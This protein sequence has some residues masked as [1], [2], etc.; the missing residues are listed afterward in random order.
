MYNISIEVAGYCL[1]CLCFV[2]P[3]VSRFEIG[4]PFPVT[5]GLKVTAYNSHYIDRVRIW[6]RDI[7]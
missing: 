2:D 3:S 4:P 6:I 1:R 5:R 7:S